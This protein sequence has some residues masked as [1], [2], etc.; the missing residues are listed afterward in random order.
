SPEGDVLQYANP[1]KYPL[2]RRVL[3]RSQS[4]IVHNQTSATQ[5]AELGFASTVHVI[6]HLS[7]EDQIVSV[8]QIGSRALRSQLGFA[9]TDIVIGIFG[10]IGPTKRIDKVFQAVRTILNETPNLAL[11]ILV[12]G[13][14]QPFSDAIFNHKLQG[15]V[16]E[17]GFVPESK[18][19]EFMNAVDVVANLRYPSMGESSGTLIQAMALGKPVIVTNH[20]SFSELP[21]D[22][23]VKISYGLQEKV[24]IRRALRL[25]IENGEE[26]ERL[27]QAAR[28][29]VTE[30]CAPTKVADQYLSVLRA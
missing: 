23:V 3:E 7:Y 12:V 17:T 15:I 16:I 20:G 28:R 22:V 27:G 24:E 30:H 18:F 19:L 13:E 1:S 9:E 25:L 5:L 8:K 14:G 11:K 2:I 4:I 10:F 21:D 6:P 26:R 29:Y